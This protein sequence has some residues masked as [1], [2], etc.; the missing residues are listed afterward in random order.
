MN[1][2]ADEEYDFSCPECDESLVVNGSMKEAL[3]AKGCVICGADVSTDAF[4]LDHEQDASSS[5]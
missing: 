4:T 1:S 2:T 3:I 5:E